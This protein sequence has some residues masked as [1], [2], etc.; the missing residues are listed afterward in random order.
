MRGESD[1]QVVL[2][3]TRIFSCKLYELFH[4]EI[5]LL[6][7]AVDIDQIPFCGS[8]KESVELPCFKIL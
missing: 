6:N 7:K 5:L 3:E 1:G 2:I 4:G 8:P